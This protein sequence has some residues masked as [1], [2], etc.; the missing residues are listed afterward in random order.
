MPLK[1][2]NGLYR[3]KVRIGVTQDGKPIDKFVSGKTVK[4]LEVAK[5]AAR[6]HFIYGRA[7]PKNVQ[8]FEYAEQWY[9]LK[10]E[11][12][13][14]AASRASYKSCFMKHLLPEFGLQNLR[15]ID[16][17]QIQ[18]F[19]NQFAGTSKSQITQIIGT[20]KGIFSS[21][22]AEGIID[23]DPSAALVCPKAKKK[24][25][26]R[27]LTKEETERVLSVMHT[28]PEGLLLA[29]LY[30][31]GVR[32]GEAL[33]LQ[34][35]DFDFTEDQVHIQRD[36]DYTGSTAQEGE[37][38]TRASDRFVPVPAELK[39]MLLP[40]KGKK[41]EYIFHTKKGN[42]IS[43]SS[44]R[45]MWLRLMTD[46]SCVEWREIDVDTD[47]PEDI[48]KQVKPTL[49]PHFFRHNYVTML[50]EAGV[51]PLV[52]MKI[53]GHSNYQTTADVYTHI[54]DDMLKK[55]TINMADVFKR[56]EE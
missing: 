35:G 29:V 25:D 38:K 40:V 51:E 53:V 23:R 9:N 45:R 21:A 2:T 10:M 1:K 32:R 24:D 11:P 33:G 49:T 34:W 16:A 54:R 44:F 19:V 18:K 3:G 20:L 14:S 5:E 15:A 26:R 42:P 22:L 12:F 6:D 4:E 48:R 13:I 41:D 52:A 27:P 50:Y 55:A 46:C 37:L 56:R 31:L 43:E 30:Y 17:A 28:N 7:I 8:F 39:A 36:I 47:R